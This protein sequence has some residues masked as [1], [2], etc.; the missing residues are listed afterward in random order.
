MKR[1]LIKNMNNADIEAILLKF[2]SAIKEEL[3]KLVEIKTQLTH[4]HPPVKTLVSDCLYCK[5][6]GNVFHIN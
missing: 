3:H 4:N 1:L 5:K 6:Y 2:Q